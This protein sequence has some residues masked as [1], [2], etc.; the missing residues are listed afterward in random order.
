MSMTLYLLKAPL[1]L[2]V[3]IEREPDLFRQV[4]QDE[5]VAS[6]AREGPPPSKALRRCRE[7]AVDGGCLD[8]GYLMGTAVV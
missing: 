2:A 6:A 8:G 7:R 4:W 1:E 3:R 5:A